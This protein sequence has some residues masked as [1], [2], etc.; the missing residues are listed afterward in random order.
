MVS[1]ASWVRRCARR[2]G[3]GA[4]W[5]DHWSFNMSGY[6]AL[7]ISD[8]ALFRYPQYHLL[9]DTPDKVDY[10]RLARVTKGLEHVLRD[11]AAL[12]TPTMRPLGVEPLVS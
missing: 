8:T 10:E 4:G 1:G 9:S 2:S 6:P 7:M 3:P 11:V 12:T 5:S